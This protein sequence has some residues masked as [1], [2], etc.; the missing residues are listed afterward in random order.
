MTPSAYQSDWGLAATV[1]L[2]VEDLGDSEIGKDRVV[3]RPDKHVLKLEV[4]VDDS[5]GM[6][7]C[8][9]LAQIVV[10]APNHL[11][12]D[13][14]RLDIREK[15]HLAS[16]VQYEVHHEIRL[17]SFAVRPE[18]RHLHYARMVQA[19]EKPP[20]HEK[21]LA[22]LGVVLLVG[23]Q[24]DRVACAKLRILR[25]VHLAHAATPEKAHQLVWPYAPPLRGGGCALG[26]FPVVSGH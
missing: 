20:L 6:D 11:L 13:R 16:A 15:L 8:E 10:P 12:V 3:V 5:V 9:P 17:P 25:L 14:A 24:L 19:G 22:H 26:L 2:R 7:V 4:P 1:T 23:I 21:A 18:V